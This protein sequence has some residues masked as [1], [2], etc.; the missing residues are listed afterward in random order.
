[1]NYSYWIKRLVWHS[2][3]GF[4]LLCERDWRI[5]ISQIFRTYLDRSD[6]TDECHDIAEHVVSIEKEGQWV[7]YMTGD[8]LDQK[9]SRGEEQHQVQLHRLKP[10]E[11]LFHSHDPCPQS[12]VNVSTL[13]SDIAYL[14]I[15]V[16]LRSHDIVA[17]I[18]FILPTIHTYSILHKL[19]LR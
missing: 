4:R 11:P 3:H 17:T 8:D 6:A 7:R 5:W 14:A 13:C 19:Y 18:C 15:I 12:H 16:I 10:P 1:M 2:V 9:E